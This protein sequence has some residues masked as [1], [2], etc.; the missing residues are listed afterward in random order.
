[1][2]AETVGHGCLMLFNARYILVCRM[3]ACWVWLSLEER[4]AASL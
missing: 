1:M 2:P 3:S 4:E